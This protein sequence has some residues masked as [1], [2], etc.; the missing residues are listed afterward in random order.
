[1]SVPAATSGGP[2]AV[3]ERIRSICRETVLPGVDIGDHDDFFDAGGDSIAL[4]RLVALVQ[5]EFGIEIRAI[6]FFTHPTL[7]VLAAMVE[8][9]GEDVSGV[10]P[11]AVTNTGTD[12]VGALP[13]AAVGTARGRAVVNARTAWFVRSPAVL[14]KV[15]LRV[16]CLPYA[17]AGAALFEGWGTA[18]PPAAELVPPVV[19]PTVVPSGRVIVNSP[20]N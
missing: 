4:L 11:Q 13:A 12:R 2:R 6:E 17:G 14:D 10:R 7:A 5:Y 18:L 3:T 16:F 8:Q 9:V 1:M 20:A 19:P 15:G